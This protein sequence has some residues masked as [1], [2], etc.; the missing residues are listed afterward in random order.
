M[1]DLR[2]AF[3]YMTNVGTSAQALVEVDFYERKQGEFG[4]PL[5]EKWR[6]ITTLRLV[7]NSALSQVH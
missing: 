5:A 1:S 6:T 2:Y 3:E 4:R 7:N